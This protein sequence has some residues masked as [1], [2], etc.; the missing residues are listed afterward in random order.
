MKLANHLRYI[1]MLYLRGRGGRID[2]LPLA[3]KA[4]TLIAPGTSLAKAFR[5]TFLETVD[6]GLFMAGKLVESFVEK[7]RFEAA[8]KQVF[9]NIAGLAIDAM[10][11]CCKYWLWRCR[12]VDSGC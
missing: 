11:T 9:W 3:W 10:L 2:C 6:D 12:S 4:A 8:I 1:D 7:A 5:T